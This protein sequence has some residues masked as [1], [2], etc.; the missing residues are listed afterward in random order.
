MD[1]QGR[2]EAVMAEV[3]RRF[4]Q[5]LTAGQAPNIEHLARDGA[6]AILGTGAPQQRFEAKVATAPGAA[7]EPVVEEQA[8]DHPR[9]PKPPVW[10]MRIHRRDAGRRHLSRSMGATGNQMQKIRPPSTWSSET[11]GLGVD[12]HRELTPG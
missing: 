4:Q 10:D 7:V 11:L 1:D 5:A 8:D 9:L 6:L 2:I 3:L 12:P